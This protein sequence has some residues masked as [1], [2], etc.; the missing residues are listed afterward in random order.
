[1]NVSLISLDREL[2]RKLE[3]GAP[4]PLSR[5]D[6]IERL[7]EAGI[8]VSVFLAPVLPGLT[9]D[10]DALANVVR[11]AAEHGASDVW[12]GAL[13]LPEGIRDHFLDVVS[14]YFPQVGENY[15]RLYAGRPTLPTGYQMRVE[16]DVSQAR[17]KEG[18]HGARAM[19]R[20]AACPK[21]AQLALPI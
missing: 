21:K 4:A 20:P 8:P 2:L 15:E 13:R 18:L 14:G 17:A 5:L 3:P 6:T 11:A 1:M 7:A 10:P 16:H 12:T 19:D 9:D